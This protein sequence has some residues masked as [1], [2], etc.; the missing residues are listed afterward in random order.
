MKNR[1]TPLGLAQFSFPQAGPRAPGHSS[2]SLPP[3][4]TVHLPYFVLRRAAR[5][6]RGRAATT[7]R[8]VAEP[9]LAAYRPRAIGPPVLPIIACHLP[10]TAPPLPHPTVPPL[11]GR[12][13]GRRSPFTPNCFS[14]RPN[15][16]HPAP[17]SLLASVHRCHQNLPLR[18]QERSLPH[19]QPT[20]A[21]S[22]PSGQL[23]SR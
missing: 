5:V 4:P 6:H 12:H 13:P 7:A 16:E 10:L 22:P 15:C 3:G 11:K 21:V 2:L 20:C 23:S 9:L 1:T 8:T 17:L 18:H 19:H 14:L